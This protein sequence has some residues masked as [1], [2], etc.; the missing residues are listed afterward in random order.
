M[1]YD[2]SRQGIRVRSRAQ[3]FEEGETNTQYFEQLS[4]SNKRKSV[5]RELYNE[6]EIITKDKKEILKNIKS[7]YEKLYSKRKKD[8]KNKMRF[9]NNINKLNK[10]SSDSCEGKVTN[11]ECYKILKE[12]KFNK[13]PGNDGF[14]VECYVTFWP[15]LGEMLVETLNDTYEKSELSN[16]QKQGVITLLEKEGKNVLY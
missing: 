7:F 14:T 11:E 3:W 12:I 6:N 1:L 5:I 2:Y 16:S 8:D 15:Q 10:E 4:Q 13:S 9:F